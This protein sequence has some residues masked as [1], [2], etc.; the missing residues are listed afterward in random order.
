M[1]RKGFTLVE[2]L[3]VIGI[4]AVLIAIL[5]PALSRARAQALRLKCATNLKQIGEAIT[6]YT[7]DHRGTLPIGFIKMKAWPRGITWYEFI[8][9]YLGTA[10]T[11]EEIAQHQEDS[12]FWCPNWKGHKE[13]Y[14]LI[15]DPIY[16]GYIGTAWKIGYGYNIEPFRPRLRSADAM[17]IEEGYWQGIYWKFSQITHASDRGM[18]TE[19]EDWWAQCDAWNP[20]LPIERQ[21]YNRLT[22]TRHGRW[23][24]VETIDV[25]FF[26][27]HVR[28]VSPKEVMFAFHDP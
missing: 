4:I 27:G 24:D 26:D 14:A 21:P 22:P 10:R 15:N 11:Q 23:T 1:R 17:R 12:V 8:G 16:P 18:V 20:D 3:V 19:A 2:L 5:L 7:N 9:P 13:P 25:L 28:F 6:L